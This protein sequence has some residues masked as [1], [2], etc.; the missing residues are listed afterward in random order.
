[1][2]LNL[3]DGLN[4]GEVKCDIFYDNDICSHCSLVGDSVCSTDIFNHQDLCLKNETLLIIPSSIKYNEFLKTINAEFNTPV[5]CRNLSIKLIFESQSSN[6]N[7]SLKFIGYNINGN[8]LIIS[9]INLSENYLKD[10]KI[11]VDITFLNCKSL[12]YG[13]LL[14][15]KFDIPIQET[16]ITEGAILELLINITNDITNF[17]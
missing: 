12:Y 15:Q 6:S 11:K 17:F 4:L 10:S 14:N 9:G 13:E 5:K 1:V 3:C 8:I 7:F 2:P 16:Q